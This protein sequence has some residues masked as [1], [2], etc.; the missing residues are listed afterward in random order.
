[1]K[2]EKSFCKNERIVSQKQIDKLFAGDGSHSR[3]A[4]PLRVVYLIEDGMGG[5]SSA[6]VLI[7]VPKRKFRH[8][9]DRNRVKRQIREAYRLNKQLLLAAIPMGQTVSLAFIWQSDKHLPSATVEEKVKSLLASIA[10]RL[11][12]HE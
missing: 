11:S 8:A 1:M 9:V 10:R 12:D 5:M 4:F 7:S 3:A 6:Q 2:G